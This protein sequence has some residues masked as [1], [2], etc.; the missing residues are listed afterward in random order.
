MKKM[1]SGA[2]RCIGLH[3]DEE[4]RTDILFVVSDFWRWGGGGGG[5]QCGNL[6]DD[7]FPKPDI[8]VQYLGVID[9]LSVNLV[10]QKVDTSKPLPSF[11]WVIMD[12]PL[13]RPGHFCPPELCHCVVLVGIDRP[14]EIAVEG[15][16]NVLSSDDGF[17]TP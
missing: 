13:E 10:A 2:G 1:E 9:A 16:E 11:I 14:T 8:I 12:A 3:T 7:N 6:T 5:R 4:K 15:D 17:P